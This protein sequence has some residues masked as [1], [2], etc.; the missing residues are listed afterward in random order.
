MACEPFPVLSPRIHDFLKKALIE[1]MNMQITILQSL[2]GVASSKKEQREEGHSVN[3]YSAVNMHTMG[4][5][6]VRIVRDVRQMA[7]A[8]IGEEVA[9]IV[10]FQAH[11]SG[12]E[13]T[14]KASRIQVS[15]RDAAERC[16]RHLLCPAA[17]QKFERERP[18]L[19]LVE[20]AA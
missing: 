17:H 18:I 19:F 11:V 12:H 7:E 15:L 10:E 5:S 20:W 9:D 13:A 14:A 4:T 16:C 1:L 3:R 2:T 8:Q 6:F